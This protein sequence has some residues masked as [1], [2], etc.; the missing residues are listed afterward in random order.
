MSVSKRKRISSNEDL[1]IAKKGFIKPKLH[2][3]NLY[4]PL[5]DVK[6]MKKHAVDEGTTL[7]DIFCKLAKEYL[8]DR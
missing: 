6:K 8:N 3:I 1:S 5:E 7:T 2:K 4:V